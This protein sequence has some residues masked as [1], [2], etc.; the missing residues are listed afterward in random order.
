LNG[1]EFHKIWVPH[2]RPPR[3][4]LVARVGNLDPQQTRSS[5]GRRGDRRTYPENRGRQTAPFVPEGQPTIAQGGQPWEPR[6]KR[7]RSPGRAARN[8]LSASPWP[9]LAQT[10]IYDCACL[11]AKTEGYFQ[12]RG[13]HIR[14][15]EKAG[16]PIA[17]PERSRRVWT[18]RHGR[19]QF[20]SGRRQYNAIL[21]YGT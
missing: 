10:A 20:P 21:S 1:H 11:P 16:C 8:H 14:S 15:A 7:S 19:P 4:I 9:R 2:P 5:G 6:N 12:A 18:F 17:C 3:R 13:V